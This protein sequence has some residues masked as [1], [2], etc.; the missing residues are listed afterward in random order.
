MF[1]MDFVSV[2]LNL[3][4]VIHGSFLILLPLDSSLSLENSG[5]NFDE[6]VGVSDDSFVGKN[7][8]SIDFHFQ[9]IS[10][11]MVDLERSLSSSVI[12]E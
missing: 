3:Q 8:S 1:Q 10:S 7:D 5:S 4:S 6:I 12:I 9:G 11:V 2:V